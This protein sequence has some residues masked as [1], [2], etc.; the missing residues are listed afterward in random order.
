MDAPT[1]A[2]GQ[3][4]LVSF[5]AAVSRRQNVGSLADPEVNDTPSGE[6]KSP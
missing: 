6:T 5:D 2:S 3:R 4:R 1:T